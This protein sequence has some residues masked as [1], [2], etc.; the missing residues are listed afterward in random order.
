M[1]S[2]VQRIRRECEKNIKNIQDNCQHQNW[3]WIPLPIKELH[4]Q[5]SKE[6][7]VKICLYCE[8]L[9]DPTFVGPNTINP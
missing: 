4:G 6:I 5:F 8:K 3:R 2:E 1:E 9:F 7:M